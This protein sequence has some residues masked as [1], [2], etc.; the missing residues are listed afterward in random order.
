MASSDDDYSLDDV[1]GL[2]GLESEEEE[3]VASSM[4]NISAGR[5]RLATVEASVNDAGPSEQHGQ[6]GSPRHAKRR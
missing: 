1:S 2:S 5:R 3:V 4:M 6:R